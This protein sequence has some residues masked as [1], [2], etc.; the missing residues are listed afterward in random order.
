MPESIGVRPVPLPLADLHPGLE[1]LVTPKVQATCIGLMT[2]D[3]AGP[4]TVEGFAEGLPVQL[5]SCCDESLAGDFVTPVL[6]HG[7]DIH[8][9]DLTRPTV[10]G[11]QPLMKGLHP[12]EPPSERIRADALVVVA[13]TSSPAAADVPG[14][15]LN[16]SARPGLTLGMRTADCLT[17]AFV[18]PLPLQD[19]ESAPPVLVMGLVHLGWRSLT[20]GLHWRVVATLESQL[21]SVGFSDTRAFWDRAHHYLGPTIAGTDYPCGLHDVGVAL[22]AVPACLGHLNLH[23]PSAQ[24]RERRSS[25]PVAGLARQLGGFAA[26]ACFPDLQLLGLLDLLCLGARSESIIVHRVNTARSPNYPSY[27]RDE[28]ERQDS[29]GLH[30]R[31]L[32]TLLHFGEGTHLKLS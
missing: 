14:A 15:V 22:H 1:I 12:N 19:S 25:A 17:W 13:S 31:R 18:A 7:A 11:T 24:A 5:E 21:R 10:C 32:V 6:V 2:A 3:R 29:S 30:K 16:G 9:V 27:R 4:V 26:D 20:A 8:V 28:R 23:G